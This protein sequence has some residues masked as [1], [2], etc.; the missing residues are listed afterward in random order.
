M[1]ESDFQALAAQWLYLE[2]FGFAKAPPQTDAGGGGAEHGPRAQ[3]G[4]ILV[5][6]AIRASSVDGY[7]SGERAAVRNV[8]KALGIDEEGVTELEQLVAEEQALTRRR[9]KVLR[10]SGHPNLDPKYQP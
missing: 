3:S 5:Y 2:H 6:D 9:I 8:A 4:R 1:T 10:P 7:K